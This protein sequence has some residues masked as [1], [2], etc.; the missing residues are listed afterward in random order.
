MMPRER[1]ANDAGGKRR[2]VSTERAISSLELQARFWEER[3]ARM[4]DA[5]ESMRRQLRDAERGSRGVVARRGPGRPPGP[6]RRGGRR[7]TP[8]AGSVAADILREWAR[9]ARVREILPEL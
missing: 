4:R 2:L 9:P 3:A 8:G 6:G 5:V 1:K 7:S